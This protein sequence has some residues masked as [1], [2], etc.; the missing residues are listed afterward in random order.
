MLTPSG[1]L[2]LRYFKSS[3]QWSWVMKGGVTSPLKLTQKKTV[4]LFFWKLSGLE[5]PEWNITL[6]GSQ[7]PRLTS[8]KN[9]GYYCVCAR[10]GMS[11]AESDAE[12]ERF[13]L[14]IRYFCLHS[15]SNIPKKKKKGITQIGKARGEEARWEV[16]ADPSLSQTLDSPSNRIYLENDGMFSLHWPFN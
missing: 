12:P 2:P 5:F 13:R 3:S 7:E 11:L 9:Q 16:A 10:R 6:T 15:T 14:F 1:Q 4:F 8:S